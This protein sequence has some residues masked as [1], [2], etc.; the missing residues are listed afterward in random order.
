MK[1][2]VKQYF[3]VPGVINLE[4]DGFQIM[5]TANAYPVFPVRIE[6]FVE[7]SFFSFN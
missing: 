7:L 1:A 5:G 2:V 4:F 6:G 3:A